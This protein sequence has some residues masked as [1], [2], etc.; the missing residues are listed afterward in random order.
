MPR[1][2][3]M[4]VEVVVMFSLVLVLV[5]MEVAITAGVVAA[6]LPATEASQPEGVF[7]AEATCHG[8]SATFAWLRNKGYGCRN[9]F[10]NVCRGCRVSDDGV[11]LVII[12]VRQ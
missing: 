11:K 2:M 4:V 7:A 6:P 8:G 3:V 10:G 5:L 12:V 9:R 1:E